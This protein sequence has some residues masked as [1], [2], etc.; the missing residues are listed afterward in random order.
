[1]SRVGEEKR[2]LIFLVLEKGEARCAPSHPA[3]SHYLAPKEVIH[4]VV[5]RG[6][7]I[8]GG[9]CLQHSVHGDKSST[10]KGSGAL[11]GPKVHKSTV[12]GHL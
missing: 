9:Y 11:N 7:S 8:G 4:V 3:S 2:G 5:I 6:C 1:M 12:C 10:L